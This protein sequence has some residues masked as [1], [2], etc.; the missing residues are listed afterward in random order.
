MDFF[1]ILY[2]DGDYND[3]IV[4]NDPWELGA[5]ELFAFEFAI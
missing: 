1:I 4:N 5:V 2:I 3:N